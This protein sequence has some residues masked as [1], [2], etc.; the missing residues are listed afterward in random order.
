MEPDSQFYK[1]IMVRMG[2]RKQSNQMWSLY[3]EM[4]EKGI[5]FDS[6]A[7]PLLSTVCT[8]LHKC[9]QYLTDM[10]VCVHSLVKSQSNSITSKALS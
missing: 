6:G 4:K 7:Y 3:L 1:Y 2:Q 9:Q 10:K 5:E 8:T